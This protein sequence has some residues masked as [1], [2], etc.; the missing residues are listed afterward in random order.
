MLTLRISMVLYEEMFYEIHVKSFNSVLLFIFVYAMN[1][2]EG[3]QQDLREGK[4]AGC[5]P[6]MPYLLGCGF[7]VEQ[8]CYQSIGLSKLF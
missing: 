5:T 2:M 6:R 3:L 4:Y 7:G 1:D 8:A